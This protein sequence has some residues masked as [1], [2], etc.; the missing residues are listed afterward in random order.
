M[1]CG[2][3]WVPRKTRE[4]RAG[5]PDGVQ[6]TQHIAYD[7]CNGVE[8]LSHMSSEG[9]DP[10]Q[11]ELEESAQLILTHAQRQGSRQGTVQGCAEHLT[12]HHVYQLSHHPACSTYLLDASYCSEA[13]FYSHSCS[14]MFLSCFPTGGGEKPN[15]AAA[16]MRMKPSSLCICGPAQHGTKHRGPGRG[17]QAEFLSLLW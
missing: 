7:H 6:R 11:G 17:D 3:W 12:P 10:G 2:I 5:R 9:G 16:S 4:K 13:S 14:I 15:T 1:Q 8:R